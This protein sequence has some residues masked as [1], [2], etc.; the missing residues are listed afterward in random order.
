M[1]TKTALSYN[2]LLAALFVVIGVT[3]LLS[4]SPNWFLGIGFLCLSG[5]FLLL[6][7]N[8]Q[9]W[10]AGPQWRRVATVGVQIIA[11]ALIVWGLFKG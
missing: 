6:G 7:G 2:V 8:P 1:P 3:S 5:S 10:R 9:A 4:N 11:A